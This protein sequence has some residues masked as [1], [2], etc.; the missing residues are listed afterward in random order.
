MLCRV[1]ER[2]LSGMRSRWAE[3]IV[4]LVR[5]LPGVHDRGNRVH[6]LNIRMTGQGGARVDLTNP[7]GEPTVLLLL[8]GDALV[9]PEVGS[10][11]RSQRATLSPKVNLL[12]ICPQSV[13][14]LETGE[15][16]TVAVTKDVFRIARA[17]GVP[18]LPGSVLLDPAG[19]VLWTSDARLKVMSIELN[20]MASPDRTSGAVGLGDIDG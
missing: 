20:E 19:S 8:N 2:T 4:G 1:S 15:G 12:V 7:N 5:M 18:E 10:M 9:C 11:V 14:C 17:L 16:Y 13:P 3:R 6:S